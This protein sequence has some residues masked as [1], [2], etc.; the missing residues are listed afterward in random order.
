MASTSDGLAIQRPA[1][2]AQ[3]K[4]EVFVRH[5][6]VDEL[7]DLGINLDLLKVNGRKAV[8]LEEHPSQLVFAH[9]PKLDQRKPYTRS[10]LLGVCKRGFELSGI[11]ETLSNEQ[12]TEAKF[13]DVS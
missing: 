3:W 9:E 6:P 11:D 1:H 5:L 10:A 2:P 4:H 13:C 12:V 8:L 7:I